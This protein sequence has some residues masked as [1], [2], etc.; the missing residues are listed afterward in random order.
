M[1]EIKKEE[2]KMVEGGANGIFVGSIIGIVVTFIV[3]VLHG[4]S[5]PKTCND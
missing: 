2:M 5:N 3:G 1:R 4:Y